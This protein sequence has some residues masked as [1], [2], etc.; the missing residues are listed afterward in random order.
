MKYANSKKRVKTNSKIK[1][2]QQTSITSKTLC[3]FKK[4]KVNNKVLDYY[5]N[6]ITIQRQ[7][8]LKLN[9]N[10]NSPETI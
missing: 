10:C 2:Q 7:I 4:T 5:N 1:E 6:V 3:P 8:K 9:K